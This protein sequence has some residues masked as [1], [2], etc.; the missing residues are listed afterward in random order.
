MNKDKTI[1]LKA[2][3]EKVLLLL[4]NAIQGDSILL[5]EKD[6]ILEH[7]RKVY[8]E[9][10]LCEVQIP[11]PVVEERCDT[12]DNDSECFKKEGITAFSNEEEIPQGGIEEESAIT[13]EELIEQP[14]NQ[15]KI[16]RNLIESLYGDS[17]LCKKTEPTEESVRIE[18][19]NNSSDEAVPS[20]RV[21]NE[22]L[23][24]TVSKD[25]ASM[26]SSQ[27][28]SQ[29]RNAIGL[30]DQLMLLN[31][32]F[33]NDP[34]LYEKTLTALDACD[35]IDDAYIYLYEHFTLDDSKEGVKCLISLL[36]TKY[37]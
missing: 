7:L 24:D 10:S 6:I 33:D 2:E 8:E 35:N 37:S 21:W 31:D 30:N 13:M 18:N 17:S 25:V 29:L 26:L 9:I 5:I 1:E 34:E 36:E 19:D 20:G 27:T 16:D 15:V 22:T 28:A 4:D 32:L 11:A 12:I 14:F 3:L 23:A